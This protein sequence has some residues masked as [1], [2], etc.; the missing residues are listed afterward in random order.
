VRPKSLILRC[1]AEREP[2]GSWF[3][4]CLDLSVHATGDTLE[5]AKATL[6]ERIHAYV[7]EALTVDSEHVH[8]LIPRRA[9]VYFWLR[10]WRAC[11]LSAVHRARAVIFNDHLPLKPA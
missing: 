11:C 4:V 3:V 9:P 5:Q 10:Y 1:L 2:D 8:D 6:H 7:E